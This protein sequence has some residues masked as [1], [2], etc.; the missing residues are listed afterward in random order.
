L[1]HVGGVRSR[2]A[3]ESA[4]FWYDVHRNHE[5]EHVDEDRPTATENAMNRE[6]KIHC[7][8]VESGL[9]RDTE[10][11][12]LAVGRIWGS[13]SSLWTLISL[14]NNVGKVNGANGGEENHS[15]ANE[16]EDDNLDHSHGS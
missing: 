15:H 11:N 9:Y 2:T 4:K 10:E 16:D 6:S 14:G 7:G 5:L 8:L 12:G 3:T 13:L 1:E